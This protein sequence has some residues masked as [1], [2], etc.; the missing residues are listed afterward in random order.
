[1]SHYFPL[2]ALRDTSVTHQPEWFPLKPRVQSAHK[3]ETSHSQQM[4]DC[5][6]GRILNRRKYYWQSSP[7]ETALRN[8]FLNPTCTL[9]HL[10]WIKSKQILQCSQYL[11]LQTVGNS[12]N[13]WG[14]SSS[15][16]DKYV[17]GSNYLEYEYVELQNRQHKRQCEGIQEGGESSL[18]WAQ[19]QPYNMDFAYAMTFHRAIL[20]NTVAILQVWKQSSAK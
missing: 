9:H 19:W 4:Q 14:L 15:N 2:S 20:W 5:K 10:Y 12:V 16:K 13:V 18:S 6:C 3:K 1:M 7:K 17:I 8:I 11:T